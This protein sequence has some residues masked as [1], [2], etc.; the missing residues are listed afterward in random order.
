MSKELVMYTRTAGCPFVTIA[1]KVLAEHSIP[2]REIFI[3]QDY[4]ARER[5]LEWVGFLSVPTLVV[6]NAGQDVP[7]T[8][9][10]YLEKGQSPRGIDRGAMLTE[11]NAA[12]LTAWLTR[13][14]F[15]SSA[16]EAR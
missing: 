10:G 9:P 12:Q 2:Y 8:E 16:S 13:H 7:F 14:A 5:L 6:A 1:K 4:N 3:D 15:I 11:P